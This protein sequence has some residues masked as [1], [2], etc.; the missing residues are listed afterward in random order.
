MLPNGDRARIVAVSEAELERLELIDS[1]RAYHRVSADGGDPLDGDVAA[2]L[3]RA[4]V[5]IAAELV[6]V[7]QRALDMAIEYAKERKTFVGLL[8]KLARY[9]LGDGAPSTPTAVAAGASG[10]ESRQR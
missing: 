7:A 9:E 6:G 3:Q 4:A 5:A 8:A 1:T 2:G 10:V